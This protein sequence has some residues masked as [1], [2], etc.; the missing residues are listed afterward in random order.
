VP[1]TEADIPNVYVSVLL[2]KGRTNPPAAVA[3][4]IGDAAPVVSERAGGLKYSNRE[5][6]AVVNDDGGDPGKPA[7]RLGY[8]ELKVEDAT[9]KL[10]VMLRANKQEYRPA[11]TAR[12]DVEV[13]DRASQPVA[14]EVTLWAVDYGV[15]SLTGFKTP[16]LVGSIYVDKALQVMTEDSRERLISRRV[17]VPKGTDDGGGGGNEG[18]PGTLRKDFRVL[19]FWLGSV[20]TDARGRAT[21]TVTLPESLTTYRIMAVAGDRT[22]RFGAADSDIRINK[23]VLLKAAFPRFMAV[24][25]SA[26]FGSVITNQLKEAGAAVVTMR[27]LDPGVLELRGEARKSVDMAAGGSAEVR[28]E[29]IGK[30]IGRARVQMSVRLRDEGDA[31]EDVVPVEVLVSPETVAAYGE[32]RPDAREQIAMPSGA[33][34]GFGGLRVE[35]ASTAMVGLGEGAQYLIDY[36]YGCAEQRSSRTLALLLSAD[37][38][39]AFKLPGVKPADL[40]KTVQASVAELPRFQ[41]PN[42]AFAYWPGACNLTSPVL[43]AYVL[44]V[45]QTARAMSYDVTSDVLDRGYASLQQDLSAEPSANEG[46]SP[47]VTAWEA[48]AVKVLVDGGRNQD[49]TLNRL[50]GHRETMPVFALA[51]MADALAGRLDAQSGKNETSARLED[52]RRRIANAILPEAGGSHVEELSDPYLLWFWNSNIRSTAIVLANLVRT[53]GSDTLIAPMVRWLLAARRNGRWGNTQENAV[54]ME[55]LVAY[56]RKFEKEPPNFTAVVSLGTRELARDRFEGRSTDA[57]SRELPMSA[58]ATT[59]PAGSTRDLTFR[60]EGTGTLF[61]NARL[62]Y[63]VD[64]LFQK[65]LDSGFAVSRKYSLVDADGKTLRDATAFQAG[66]LIRVTLGFELTKERRFVAVVDPLAA[67]LEPIESGFESTAAKLAEE[68]DRSTDSSTWHEWWRR[69]GFDHSERHDD[70]VLFFATRLSEGRHET[71]YLARATTAGTF[72]TAPAHAEEMYQPEVFGRTP[73]TIIEVKR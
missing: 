33:V 34:P 65:G 1:L 9:K 18:G 15:L 64:T 69:G 10:T 70:R 47:W 40:K 60:R 51:Y 2:L 54:A 48:F 72:R 31:F 21:T 55:A 73:T 57:R 59:M 28:F 3:P 13:K 7:F 29:A 23:P 50:Y 49:S 35:L 32:A 67:G 22:S 11:S 63:A 52:L 25:D 19:A 68:Q 26:F 41:C 58:L 38:G 17:M 24:G 37:L 71:S 20:V 36:P 44:H 43:T 53:G 56:Y 61:Y 62:R 27:S 8:T 39:E 5:K 12:I 16:N 66:D 6:Q 14:S 46:W 42:G 4:A 30:A 45:L